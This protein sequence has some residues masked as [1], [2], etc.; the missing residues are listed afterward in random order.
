MARTTI[1]TLERDL[2]AVT[3]ERD[4]LVTWYRYAQS[5]ATPYKLTITDREDGLAPFTIEVHGIDAILACVVVVRGMWDESGLSN[6]I[7]FYDLMAAWLN[8]G[9][10]PRLDA[11][12]KMLRR[13]AALLREARD[14]AL[15]IEA[16]E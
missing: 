11:H 14:L 4:A 13:A 6:P 5:G 9:S 3:R 7:G 8:V 1:K 2:A 15:E 10:A 12:E 16:D